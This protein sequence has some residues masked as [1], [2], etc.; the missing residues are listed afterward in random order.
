M[1]IEKKTWPE[2]FQMILDG[3]KNF[4]IRLADFDIKEGDIFILREWDPDKKEYT[5]RIMEKEVLK[6]IN[7]NNMKFQSEEEI[8]KYGFWVIGF[9]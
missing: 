8:H 3:K 2:Y 7:T 6:A 9:K 1:R 4:D 5:G